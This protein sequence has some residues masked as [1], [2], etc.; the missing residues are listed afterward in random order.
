MKKIAKCLLA[1]ACASVLL[2]GASA[3]GTSAYQVAVQNGYQGTEKEWLATLQGKDGKDGQDLTAKDLY[4]Y[5]LSNGFTGT[6]LDFCKEL[7][8]T[9]SQNNN[10]DTIARNVT[11]VVSIYCGFSKTSY[12]NGV[13]GLVGGL[14]G[15]AEQQTEA[16]PLNKYVLNKKILKE[17]G[18]Y[19]ILKI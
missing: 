17:G 9:V 1:S 8:I 6:Y 15:G 10:V 5:A 19:N 12:S 18:K 2:I 7:G 16:G 3:C 4:E 14:I 11:S 13:G